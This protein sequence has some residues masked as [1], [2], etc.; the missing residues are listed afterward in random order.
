MSLIVFLALSILGVGFL[1]YAFF[2]WTYGDKRN[3]LNRQSAAVLR[4]Y[5][6]KERKGRMAR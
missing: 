1:I 6:G 5:R 3:A 4:P 2:Q